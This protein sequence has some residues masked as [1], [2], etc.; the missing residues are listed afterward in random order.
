MSIFI[1][2]ATHGSPLKD[3]SRPSVLAWQVLCLNDAHPRTPDETQ[4]AR[5][6]LKIE[7]D[8]KTKL[9]EVCLNIPKMF[10]DCIWY[11]T[12]F[13]ITVFLRIYCLFQNVDPTQI[14]QR[15]V[16]T[17][18]VKTELEKVWT[19]DGWSSCLHHFI[20]WHLVG[21]TEEHHEKPRT[22]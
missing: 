13:Y 19:V 21:G 18:E 5:L 7:Q 1:E 15:R 6:L 12:A 10:I 20:S 16:V 11:P 3:S 2:S 22:E 8:L 17:W 9:K 14:V 4:T